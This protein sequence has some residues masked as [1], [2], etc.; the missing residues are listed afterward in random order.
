M[1]T[2]QLWQSTTKTIP[3]SSRLSEMRCETPT[4][5]GG[6]SPVLQSLIRDLCQENPTE[7]SR[8]FIQRHDDFYQ[9]I[10][11]RQDSL[12]SQCPAPSAED[13]Q[14]AAKAQGMLHLRMLDAIE[15]SVQ[16]DTT[17]IGDADIDD[18]LVRQCDTDVPIPRQLGD[19]AVQ[20]PRMSVEV[21]S[22][23]GFVEIGHLAASCYTL[24]DLQS[25]ALQLMCRFLDKYIANPDST[26]QHLQYVGGPG[27]T[28]KSRIVD[29]LRDVF[30]A[31]G[32]AHHL[33]ITGTSG[34]AA[35]QIGGTTL[36]SACGLD[37]HRSRDKQQPPVFSEAK[38]WMWKQKLALVIDEVSMLGGT[39][40][41]NAHSRLQAL[42]DCPDKPFGGIPV[43]LL[44]GDFYQF[45]P[46][47]E[48]SL[49]VDRMVDLAY[50]AS[51]GQATIAHHRGHSLWLMFKTVILLEEQVRAR[52]DPQL[53]ALL[54]RVRAGTQTTEDLDLLNTKLM[55]RSKV[56]FKD[57]LRAITP[58]NRNRWSLNME[59][60]VDWARFHGRHVSVFVSTHTWR[61]RALS[62]Q[63]VART[64]EQGDNSNCK[65]PGVF[66]YAQ[67]MPVVVNKNTYTGLKVVNG[68]E[69]V[70]ADIIPDPKSPGYH[71]VDDVTIHFGPPLGILLES[72]E[73]KVLAIPAL[74][75]GT[76]LI[77][78][79]THTLDPANSHYRFLSG[80]CSRR[81]LPVVPA[82]VLTDYKAQ[83]KTFE[84]V[85]LEL[86]GNRITNGQPSKCDFASLYVQLSRC[87]TLQG[88]KLLSPVRPQDFI[89]NK[90]D[91]SII[92]AMQRLTDLAAETKRLFESQRILA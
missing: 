66:F 36:H 42:R 88:I 68:A 27:G 26:G 10:R 1:A 65:I 53:G 39:T 45:A 70:A 59:A 62:Q 4:R 72:A 56:T 51:L 44:M 30:A 85:L 80:K 13:V 71:L 84:D 25:M 37:I 32:Q 40:L 83:G 73:T 38:K 3:L 92:D 35:A 87:R 33:Q 6:G 23:R 22:T 48:T 67:G 69:F 55:D 14:A 60:V 43:I 57:G 52:D 63:E 41:F 75:T 76:V 7:E 31:R 5:R 58:L 24:N 89:G 12:L 17:S 74:P 2:S 16:G 9:Q 11:R 20:S 86:R 15:G 49:L 64:I 19:S 79:I 81:G 8:P 54:D 90:P 34:S 78:P 91:Q 82:F 46:V 77:R 29:A 21:G 18:L 61:G 47:L 28:G 50:M